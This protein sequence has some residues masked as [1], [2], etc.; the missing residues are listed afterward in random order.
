MKPEADLPDDV[1]DEIKAHRK[2]NAIKLLRQHRRMDLKAA[3]DLVEAYIEQNPPDPSLM[4]P[5][6][7]TGIGRIVLLIVGVGV[8]FAIYRYFS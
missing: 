2:V 1:I 4:P 3:K 7:E 5:E 8:I 6:A